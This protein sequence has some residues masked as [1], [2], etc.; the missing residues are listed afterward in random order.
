MHCGSA[1]GGHAASHAATRPD[2]QQLGS[3]LIILFTSWSP[4]SAAQNRHSPFLCSSCS[5]PA[6]PARRSSSLQ[7]PS[8][9]LF[10][11]LAASQHHYALVKLHGC[12]GAALSQR[13]HRF[14]LHRERSA[15]PLTV[16][17][18]P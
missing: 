4:S 2:T 16:A 5:A 18:P 1:A 6:S 15:M 11:S 12:L 3:F 9:H 10:A 8:S 13:C 17:M 14:S 7:F